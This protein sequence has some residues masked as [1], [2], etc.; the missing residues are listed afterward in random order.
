M[1]GQH[2]QKLKVKKNITKLN[3]ILDSEKLV[4]AQL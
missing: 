2:P 1:P 4:A 3:F